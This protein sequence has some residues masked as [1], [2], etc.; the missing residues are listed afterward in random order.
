MNTKHT[1]GGW[2]QARLAARVLSVLAA[3]A[4][5][6]QQTAVPTSAEG[7]PKTV[8]LEKFVVTGS[9]IPYSVDAPAVPVTMVGIDDIKDTGETD[10]LEVLRKAVPQFVGNAN[11]G[12]QNSSIG[13]GD[14]NGGSRLSLRN[15]QTLVLINGRRAAFAPVSATGGYDF[16]D[17]N[18]IP[19]AAVESIEVLKDGASALYGSDAVSGVV[20]I[21]LKKN[22]QGAEVGGRYRFADTL[23]GTWEERSA[24]FATGVS[25]D[26]TAITLTFEWA[27]TDPLFQ[28][29]K[30]F[31][32]SQT[33]KTSAYPGVLTT[34]GFLGSANPGVYRLVAGKVPPA[35][36]GLTF[37]QLVAQG[38]YERQGSVNFNSQF[39]ISE[40]V[41]LAL[42]SERRAFTT[43]LSHKLT[44]HIELFGDLLYAQTDTFLQLAAQPIFGMPI[45]AENVTD[46]GLGIGFTDP[47]HPTN[48]SSEYAY[49]RNR[50]VTN[51]RKYYNET[52]SLRGL[53][54]L[55]GEVGENYR[56]EV[57]A[58]LNQIK[59]D[60][61]NAN[62]IARVNL[63]NAIDNGI[64]NLFARDQAAGAFEQGNVFGTAFSK[65][66]STLH[67][68]DA[69]VVGE[70]PDVLPA[71]PIGFAVGAETRRETLEARPDAGSYTI[72]DLND[73]LNGNPVA[74]DGATTTDPFDVTRTVDSYYAEVRVPLARDA[75][76][77]PGVKALDLDLA[78]RQDKYS[79]ADA[80]AVP[81]FSLRWMPFNDEFV[82][83]ATYS[84]SFTAPSLY[85]LF[86][87]TPIGSSDDLSALVFRNGLDASDIDQAA[88]RTLT[89]SAA[90][91]QGFASELLQPEKAD[92]YNLGIVW[93]P[94]GLRGFSA[95][96]TYFKIDQVGIAG[97][98]S[99]VD[100]LQSVED[101][102]AASEFA[103]RVRIGSF[104]GAPVTSVGQMG[105]IY[106]QFGSMSPVFISNYAENLVAASQDGVDLT[107]NY[108]LNLESIGRFDLSLTTMWFNE[109]SVEGDDFVGTTNGRSVL[110]GGTIPR[111]TGTLFAT[112]SRASWRAGF[113]IRHVPSVTDETAALTETNPTRDQH[114]ESYTQVDAHLGYEF[115]GGRGLFSAVD[116]L[117][118]RV[119]ATNLFDRAPPS[120]AASW[121]DHNADTQTYSAIGRTLYVDLSLKF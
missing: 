30:A 103:N 23:L 62:V 21:I 41:T 42:G 67:S 14:T 107:L 24:H 50:F 98:Q 116:G 22:Y 48:P 120:A 32:R 71:G 37:D 115:R 95:E 73:P 114:V 111:W 18:A 51:P 6:A 75:Q 39:N 4:A 72:N 16:V 66:T 102:G 25:N 17:V 53:L 118:V 34:F 19:V 28:N 104:N 29:E 55:R 96:L 54:G 64:I 12:A 117:T 76:A 9:Y 86:G 36:A 77:I 2:G 7:D 63:V 91:A 15:V 90:V 20:N 27:R 101:E 45:T 89:S 68:F 35:G 60:Y 59:Q 58:N 11:M 52:H 105:A 38:I 44:N 80:P 40:Y 74:W 8:H 110:N 1:P 57:A 119:G 33:G 108:N 121:T 78:V 79:D 47:T 97:V 65:N 31:S 69:R 43:A 82:V 109:F 93:S 94:R 112:Y 56:W 83:R 70:I 46:L 87:P 113:T 100:I 92:I 99:D 106:G 26:T 85:S 88:A 61:R 49:V 3:T 81:K 10:L 84:E 13:G 5:L